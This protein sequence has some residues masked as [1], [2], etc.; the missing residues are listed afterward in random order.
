[1]KYTVLKLLKKSTQKPSR[2]ARRSYD[3]ARLKSIPRSRPLQ[4][5]S[6]PHVSHSIPHHFLHIF[7]TLLHL[8]AAL[9]HKEPAII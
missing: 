2:H 1:M 8:I 7:H 5:V 3:I 6:P 4:P 9:V